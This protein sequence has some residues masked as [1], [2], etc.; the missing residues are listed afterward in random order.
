MTAQPIRDVDE[1]GNAPANMSLDS[2][3]AA[4]SPQA[5]KNIGYPQLK[6]LG[7]LNDRTMNFLTA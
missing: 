6:G 1:K 7:Y 5:P 4:A 2:K 3:H